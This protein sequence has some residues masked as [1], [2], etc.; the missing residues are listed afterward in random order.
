MASAS[1]RF[2]PLHPEVMSAEPSPGLRSG[3]L[4]AAGQLQVRSAA[5]QTELAADL[6]REI[7]DGCGGAH[8]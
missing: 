5:T 1:G 2:H 6:R 7:L 4:E 3:Q 8:L